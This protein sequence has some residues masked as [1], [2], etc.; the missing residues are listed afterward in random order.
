MLAVNQ[1]ISKQDLDTAQWK[2]AISE[3][4]LDKGDGGWSQ[5]KEILGWQLD[6]DWGTLELMPQCVKRILDIFDKLHGWQRIGVKKWQRMLG[7]LCFMGLA[8][9]GSASLFGALQLRLFHADKHWVKITQHL[10]DHLDDF[11]AL[12]PDISH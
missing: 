8:V 10:Q 5:Q 12:A 7:E 6:S 4:K 9:P 3:K 1:V 11:K 2:E